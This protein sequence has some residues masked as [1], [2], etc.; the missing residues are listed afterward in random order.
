MAQNDGKERRYLLTKTSGLSASASDLSGASILSIRNI[1]I[2]YV[3]PVAYCTTA[4]KRPHIVIFRAPFIMTSPAFRYQVWSYSA[5][6]FFRRDSGPVQFRNA[7]ARQTAAHIRTERR[8]C[9]GGRAT[10]VELTEPDCD[11]PSVKRLSIVPRRVKHG[12]GRC[13]SVCAPM[14]LC[15]DRSL[16]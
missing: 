2:T 12:A 15:S 14:I 4:K 1:R 10:P 7:I 9:L 11:V 5:V 8:G 13:T 6:Q 16:I 3:F